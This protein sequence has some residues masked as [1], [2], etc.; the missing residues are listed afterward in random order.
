MIE[1]FQEFGK[2]FA[3]QWQPLFKFFIE[4]RNNAFFWIGLFLIGLF[5]AKFTYDALNRSK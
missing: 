5:I 2:W 1:I 4:N 3:E